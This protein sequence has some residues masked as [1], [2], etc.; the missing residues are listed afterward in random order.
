MWSEMLA[1][2]GVLILLQINILLTLFILKQK[3]DI[4]ERKELLQ[5]S[6]NEIGSLSDV[7]SLEEN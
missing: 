7:Y 6:F 2:L 1:G 4:K 3:M 5:P